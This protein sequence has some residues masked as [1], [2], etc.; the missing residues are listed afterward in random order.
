MEWRGGLGCGAVGGWMAE[1][2]NGIWSVKN[3]L[4]LKNYF[5]K[6]NQIKCRYFCFVLR[7]DFSV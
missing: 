1:E 6:E 3:K 7:Q 4:I 5:I 2:G